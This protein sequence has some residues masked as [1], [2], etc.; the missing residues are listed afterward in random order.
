MMHKSVPILTAGAALCAGAAALSQSQTAA[1]GVDVVAGMPPVVN[2]ANLYSEAR[3]G[4]L[5]PRTA[6]ELVRVYVP[7]LR[8]NN[9]YVIDP[10]ARK[11]VDR[12]KVGTNPQH[13]V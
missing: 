8:S 3:A 4:N 1:P 13:I 9:V 10:V 12:F 2:A 5:S 6:S 7:N 11:V